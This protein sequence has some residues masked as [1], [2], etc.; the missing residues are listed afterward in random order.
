[1]VSVRVVL[2][3]VIQV[4]MEQLVIKTVSVSMV[5]VKVVYAYVIPIGS[6]MFVMRLL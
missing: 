6:V 3:F 2:V 5:I 1:M 4:G